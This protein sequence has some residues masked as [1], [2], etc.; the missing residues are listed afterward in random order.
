MENIEEEEA[1]EPEIQLP[2]HTQQPFRPAISNHTANN[3]LI[4][5]LYQ[6][7]VCCCSVVE[8]REVFGSD[9]G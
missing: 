9:E 1:Q 8:L 5:E 2:N 4:Y 7:K 6:R 3:K